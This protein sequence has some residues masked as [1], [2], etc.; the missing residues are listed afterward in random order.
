MSSRVSLDMP[1]VYARSNCIGIPKLIAAM[2]VS[3]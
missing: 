3:L 2:I 1:S